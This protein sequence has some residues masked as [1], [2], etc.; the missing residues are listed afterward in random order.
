MQRPALRAAADAER[1]TPSGSVMSTLRVFAAIFDERGRILS[2]R[3]NYASKGWTMPDGRVEVGESLLAALTR[4]V[5]R[6]TARHPW[7]ANGEIA[8]CGYFSLNQLPEPMSAAARVRIVDALEG[9]SGVFRVVGVPG[10]G[11]C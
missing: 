8:E 6:V 3:V 7:Q 5:M 9:R 4:E 2:V 10:H 11:V 1:W